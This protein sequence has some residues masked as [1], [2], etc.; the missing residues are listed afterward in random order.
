[1]CIKHLGNKII[2]F[3]FV[4][5]DDFIKIFKQIFKKFINLDFYNL[6]A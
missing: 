2:A 6:I 1:M 4:N 3:Y 5:V